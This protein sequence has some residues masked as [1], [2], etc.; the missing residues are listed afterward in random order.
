[1]T[2]KDVKIVLKKEIGKAKKATATAYFFILISAFCYGVF[3]LYTREAMLTGTGL[4][5]DAAA[6]SYLLKAI[7]FTHPYWE[8]QLAMNLQKELTA[9]NLARFC[10]A[11]EIAS[12]DKLPAFNDRA[13]EIFS[14]TVEKC[15]ESTAFGGEEI[16]RMESLVRKAL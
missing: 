11:L 7:K 3:F 2:G 15:R 14:E 6:I 10:A 13:R 9:D 12:E 1:M 4:L 5:F 8:M 16:D